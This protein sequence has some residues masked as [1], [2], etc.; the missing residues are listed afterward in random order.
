MVIILRSAPQFNSS[1]L[2]ISNT[3]PNI[4]RLL[5]LIFLTLV[6]WANAQNEYPEWINGTFPEDF[7]WGLATAS[8]QIEGAWDADGNFCIKLMFEEYFLSSLTSSNVFLRLQ[9]RA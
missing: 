3:I 9:G 1:F 4:M 6:V 8:Y 7:E 2:F 5:T